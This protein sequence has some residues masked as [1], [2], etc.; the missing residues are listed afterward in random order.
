MRKI[1]ILGGLFV[2]L[3]F[4]AIATT[5]A[6]AADEWLV[7]GSSVAVG[8]KV[9]VVTGE[10]WLLLALG[11]GGFIKTHIVCNNELLGTVN[12]LRAGGQ[13]TDTITEVHN[14]ALTQ[15]KKITC[16]ALSGERGPCSTSVASVEEINFPWLSELTLKT[17]DTTPRDAFSSGG[18]GAP[19]FRVECA[20]ATGKFEETCE[21]NLE[22]EQLKNEAGGIVGG[23]IKNALSSKCAVVSN[24]A[25]ITTTGTTK[26]ENGETLSVG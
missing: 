23:E 4:S 21:G 25:H 3:T 8:A 9:A 11:F 10:K 24:V 19:G 5:S 13:G 2:M 16:E 22:T 18:S 12:G 7:G 20:T 6:I 17:G 26:T 14:L 15:S 1:Q